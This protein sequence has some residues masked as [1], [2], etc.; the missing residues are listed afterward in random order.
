MLAASPLL[1]VSALAG[2]CTIEGASGMLDEL[3]RLEIVAEVT[4]MRPGAVHER[5]IP[6]RA[7]K[8]AA[9]R[10]PKGGPRGRLRKVVDATLRRTAHGWRMASIQSSGQMSHSLIL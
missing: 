5:L 10:R 3:A 8:T 9:R 1:S 4:G 6:I 2:G 7:E